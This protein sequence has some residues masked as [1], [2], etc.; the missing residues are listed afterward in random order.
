IA[1]R[2]CKVTGLVV[3]HQDG[4]LLYCEGTGADARA[5]IAAIERKEAG[6]VG[7]L[8]PGDLVDVV[9]RVADVTASTLWLE[10]ARVESRD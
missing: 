8:Q 6:R 7:G 1:R 5:L 4:H 9:G 2:A 3:S 10:D